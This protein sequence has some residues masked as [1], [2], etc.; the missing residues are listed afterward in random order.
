VRAEI[1]LDDRALE[2]ELIRLTDWHTDDLFAYLG[3]HGA[4]MF[5]NGLSRLVFDPERFLDDADEPAAAHG[6]GV[7]Y[8]RGTD[9]QR[10][11]DE[12]PELRAARVETLYRP[13][14]AALDNVV[15]DLLQSFGTC[16]LIDC[17]SF[18]SVP[19]A[20][21]L[22]QSARRPDV[23]IGTDHMHT[24]SLLAEALERAFT[25]AGFSVKRDTPFTGTFVPGGYYRRDTRVHSVMIELR[26][27][28]Y[29]D[30]QTAQPRADYDEV[31]AAI[32]RAL[33]NSGLLRT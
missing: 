15:A 29:I 24:P 8:T 27:G 9:G 6:Q 33:A 17:H 21:E 5:V 28:L 2:V 31:S 7:L 19:L 20:S 13:Y 4:T 16:T 10:L 22:D 32:G 30:E 18:P 14:H 26:R 3:S 25:G 11:R 1:V 23:C 12:S